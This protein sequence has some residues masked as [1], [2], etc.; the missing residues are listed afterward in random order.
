MLPIQR[1]TAA[2]DAS[3]SIVAQP[4]PAPTEP[5]PAMDELS[6]LTESVDQTA[7]SDLGGAHP[8]PPASLP[9]AS[10]AAAASASPA[11]SSAQ[12]DELA[13]KLF[14]PLMLQLRAELLVDRERRGL[15]TDTW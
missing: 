8:T 12:I 4:S 7:P 10:S 6:A 1:H 14:D 15:R 2:S 3:E 13:R 11:E 9:S 5:T